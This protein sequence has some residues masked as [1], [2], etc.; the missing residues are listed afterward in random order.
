LSYG[1]ALSILPW[2][3]PRLHIGVVELPHGS[4]GR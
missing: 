1:G 3:A 4:Q 2:F